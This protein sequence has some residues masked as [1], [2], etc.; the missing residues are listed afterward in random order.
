M[1]AS[2]V[3]RTLNEA[4]HLPACLAMIAAQQA[5]DLT[6]EVV[7]VDS[8]SSD[9]TVEIAR[10][11]GARITLIAKAEFSFG[12]S[13]NRGCDAATGD[14]LVFLSGHCVPVDTQ[15]L[16][17]LAAPLVTGQAVYSYGRQ[18]GDAASHFAERRIFA[19]YFPGQSA[20]P[21]DGFFCNNANAAILRS[22][23]AAHRFDE[24]LTGLED[25][26]LA[27]RLVGQ[28]ARVGYV[29][30]AAVFHHHAETWVQ[31]GRRF[32]REA[33]ALRAIMPEVTL[34]RADVVRYVATSV[35][36]DW[37]AA[38]RLGQWRRHAWPILRY[39]LAQYAGSWRGNHHQRRLSQ[40][41]KD[42]FF[43]PSVKESDPTH[44]WLDPR[45]PPHHRPSAD[46]SQ[47]PAGQGQELSRPARQAAV[48]LDP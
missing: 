4:R 11:A 46:E 9:A 39:R 25:M 27:Q 45:T 29:A 3:I 48:S 20:V 5:P 33:I 19:K 35:W 22:A 37:R 26:A 6:I 23:W 28:G 47:Q 10:A 42:R 7:L 34:T 15:W 41:E 17:R 2:I 30:E 44:A 21:Q 1:R 13:L 16:A 38:A 40:A 24:S 12:R 8:G 36:L 18:V 32:E 31:V 14:I 43:Y